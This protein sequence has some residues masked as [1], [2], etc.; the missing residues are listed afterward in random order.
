LRGNAALVNTFSTSMYELTLLS[1]KKEG[2]PS[3]FGDYKMKR[4]YYACLVVTLKFRGH[5]SQ[6]VTQ[7]G[8]YGF[9]G[10]GKT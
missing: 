10:G 2:L 6:R 9:A 5:V 4:D 1:K 7:K 3:N 8:D